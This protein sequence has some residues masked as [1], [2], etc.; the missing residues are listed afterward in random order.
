MVNMKIILIILGAVSSTPCWVSHHKHPVGPAFAPYRNLQRKGFY[1]H[2]IVK[3][4][5]SAPEI[6]PAPEIRPAPK[7]RSAP[8]IVPAGLSIR[9]DPQVPQQVV[10]NILGRRGEFGF[11]RDGH[12]YDPAGQEFINEIMGLLEMLSF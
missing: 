10:H 4:Q 2:H 3:N 9:D 12:V 7:I 1:N 6:I 8:E 11:T 5:Q